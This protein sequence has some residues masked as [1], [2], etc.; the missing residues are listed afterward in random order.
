MELITKKQIEVLKEL[1]EQLFSMIIDIQ[2]KHD[3]PDFLI[4]AVAQTV[5][6][7]LKFI[8][9]KTWIEINRGS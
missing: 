6:D 5:L 3:I 4:I 8:S 7:R 1:D 9:I 2:R